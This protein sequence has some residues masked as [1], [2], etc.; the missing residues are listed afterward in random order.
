L[1]GVRLTVLGC[2]GAWPTVGAAGSGYLVEHDRFRL[3]VDVGY[4]VVPRLQEHVA[5]ED[6]DAVLISHGHPDHCVD[7]NPRLRGRVLRDDPPPPLPVFAPAGELDAVLALDRPGMLDGGFVLTDLADGDQFRVGPFAV[8][9]RELPHS[10]PNVGLRIAASGRSLVY[11]GDS[12]ASPVTPELARDADVLLAEASFVDELPGDSAR[13]LSSADQRGEL[14][15]AANVRHLVLTH[16][17]PG[18][19]PAASAVAARRRFAGE[20]TVATTGLVVELGR[21]ETSSGHG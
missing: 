2:C 1:D 14:A 19:D 9:A 15:T 11:T 17:L 7:L 3:L 4:A 5:V 10:R 13:T 8:E 18:T 6:V 20:L 12:G 21:S 16:L